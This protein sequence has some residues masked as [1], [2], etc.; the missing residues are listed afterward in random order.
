MKKL[1]I[2]VV[3]MLSGCA[4]LEDIGPVGQIAFGTLAG[5]AGGYLATGDEQGA[6]I[7]AGVGAAAAGANAYRQHQ[8][9]MQY[10]QWQQETSHRYSGNRSST[11]QDEMRR[12]WAAQENPQTVYK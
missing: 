5:A 11:S 12:R 10:Q 4:S 8:Q 6:L 9:N 7:G 3:I 1:L 2:L